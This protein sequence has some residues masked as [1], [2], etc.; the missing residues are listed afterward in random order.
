MQIRRSRHRT[1]RE[2]I[3]S[4][5]LI[6]YFA[7]RDLARI[8]ADDFETYMAAKSRLSLAQDHFQ[9]PQLRP[10]AGSGVGV[11]A[12]PVATVKRP[13]Q[14]G[15]HREAAL[16]ARGADRI[17]PRPAD[18]AA[19]ARR[20]LDRRVI[21]VRRNIT[22]GK[23]K[24]KRPSRGVLMADRVASELERVALGTVLILVFAIGTAFASK[25]A[26]RL[27]GGSLH[28]P[29][30]PGAGFGSVLLVLGAS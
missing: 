10:R 16:S 5:H 28:L 8:T 14:A 21:R 13:R 29:P 23:P 25:D 9:P 11:S 6:P 2:S 7:Q 24:S 1:H 17:A 26:S 22:R 4:T 27:A 18:R 3:L 12:N 20:G 19:L 15:N 30:V